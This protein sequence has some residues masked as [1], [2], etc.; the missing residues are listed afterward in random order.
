VA[1][2]HQ[3]RDQHE[4][5]RHGEAARAERMRHPRGTA[6]A[7][8]ERIDG[9]VERERAERGGAATKPARDHR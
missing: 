8:L 5:R 3:R 6:L 2:R 1:A 7:E 4:Q 9:G